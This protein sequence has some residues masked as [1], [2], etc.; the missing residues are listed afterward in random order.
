[1]ATTVTKAFDELLANLRLTEYEESMAA[2]RVRNVQKILT[3]SYTCAQNPWAIGSYGRQT[4][5]RWK[6]DIDM[7]VAFGDVYWPTYQYD[8]R[9]FLYAVRNVLNKAYGNTDVSSKQ[10]AVRMLLTGG[11]QVDLV[12]TFVC[13][14]GGFYMPDGRKG[15]K[16][17]NPPYHD[18]LMTDAN[19]RLGSKLKPVVRLMKAWNHVNGR[20]LHSFHLEMVVERMW[21]NATAL[22]ATPAALCESLRAASSWVAS[23]LADP[24]TGSSEMLDAYLNADERALTVRLLKEDAARAKDALKLAEDGEMV[25]AFERWNVVFNKQFPA[26]G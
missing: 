20:H 23:S 1:M 4:L 5:V 9:S 14:S 18:T 19:V 15:W 8:S 12:P 22:P 11:L 6:R 7:M 24:W 21:R 10:V 3:E 13:A 26:Y 2:G 17:T 16:K 25:K